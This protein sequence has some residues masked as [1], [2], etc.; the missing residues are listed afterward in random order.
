MALPFLLSIIGT[1]IIIIMFENHTKTEYLEKLNNL[2]LSYKKELEISTNYQR[3]YEQEKYK[4]EM[5]K[6]CS[7]QIKTLLELDNR[8]E[9][10]KRFNFIEDHVKD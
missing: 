5:I 3:L 9:V 10:I 1:L 7:K 6:I 2:E 4:K 8:E